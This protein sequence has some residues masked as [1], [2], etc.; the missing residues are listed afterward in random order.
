MTD[1]KN[2]TDVMKPVTV[3]VVGTGDGGITRNTT[4]KT[5]NDQPN[6][7]VM[8]FTKFEALAARFVNT[9]VVMLV[10]LVGAGMTTNIIPAKDFL[11]LVWSCMQ[12]SLAAAG[13][14]ALK[15]LAT[16]TSQWA[17]DHPLLSGEV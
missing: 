15:G 2:V 12:L 5:P 7:N 8:Y 9:Y 3:N 14:D 10:A 6:L 16:I 17:K 11:Y 13:L 4:A 1:D